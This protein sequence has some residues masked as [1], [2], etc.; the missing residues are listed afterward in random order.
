MIKFLGLHW[1]EIQSYQSIHNKFV[2]NDKVP[3]T[4]LTGNTVDQSIHNIF[5]NNDKVPWTSLTVNTVDQSIHNIFV[6]NDKVPWTSL[7]GNTVDQ[8]I[9]KIFNQLSNSWTDSPYK[10]LLLEKIFN[11]KTNKKTNL[12]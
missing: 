12:V 3:W 1:K 10:I 6:N 2:N 7:T 4:S 5:V 9:H 11:L 8:S